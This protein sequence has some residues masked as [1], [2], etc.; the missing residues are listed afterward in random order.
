MDNPR[1]PRPE[2]LSKEPNPDPVDW[3]A[4]ILQLERDRERL[5]KALET[6]D[7]RCDRQYEHCGLRWMTY[8]PS[9]ESLCDGCLVVQ[10]PRTVKVCNRCAALAET[11]EEG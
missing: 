1:V 6:Q 9:K 7:C 4:Y 3:F 5:R 11:G 10:Q 8:G 2:W